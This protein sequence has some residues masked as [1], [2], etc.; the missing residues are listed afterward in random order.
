VAEGVHVAAALPSQA[1]F[2]SANTGGRL[3]SDKGKVLWTVGSLQ[4]GEERL[5][6]LQCV[7]Q[8]PGENRLQVESSAS[9]D[10]LASSGAVTLVESLADLKLEVHDPTG[11]EAVYE[12]VVRNR[13]TKMAENV[14]LMLFFSEGLEATAVHG[15]PH[16]IAPGQVVL[17]TIPSLAP[18]GEKV[19]KVHARADRPGNHIFRAE[20]VCAPLEVKLTS[21][22]STRFYGDDVGDKSVPM[23]SRR[24]G[25]T[26]Q[27]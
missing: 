19:Y 15:G 1:M 20:V 9:Q 23:I 22:Q 14:D 6:E 5:L 2:Q 27:Q 25:G 10:L 12:I 7:L 18:G 21:E 3:D 13:G 16:E 4:P 8:A 11:D 17:K 26:E 24:P